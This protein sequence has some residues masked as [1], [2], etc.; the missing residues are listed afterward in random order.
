M[1]RFSLSAF[2]GYSLSLFPRGFSV[3][4]HEFRGRFKVRSV[5]GDTNGHLARLVRRTRSVA[6]E[7][8]IVV[9]SRCSTPL[10]SILRS[11]AG[12][13]TMEAVVRRFCTPVGTGDSRVRF[14]FVAKVAGFSRLD[15]FDAVGG[16]AGVDVSP[17]FSA[18]YNVAGS[19]LSAILGRS[20][21]LLTDGGRM[22]FREVERLL[23]RGC[24]NCR[25]DQRNRSVFGPCDLVEDFTTKF[26]SGC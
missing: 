24:S 16:L 4:L 3:R 5:E 8:I 6:N 12:L 9:V 18:V 13:R 7:G 22:S 10:L 1:L 21:T 25:F 14:T 11:R 26:V 2:G 23:E 15:V 17:R 19:R 20:V